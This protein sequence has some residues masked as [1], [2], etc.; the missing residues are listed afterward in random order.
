MRHKIKTLACIALVIASS[1]QLIG[2]GGGGDTVQTT[3]PG[4]NSSAGALDLSKGAPLGTIYFATDY[5]RT[6]TENGVRIEAVRAD[7]TGR[8][9][10]VNAATGVYSFSVNGLSPDGVWLSYGSFGTGTG[11][12]ANYISKAD[13]TAARRVATGEDAIRLRYTPDSQKILYSTGDF[14]TSDGSLI[15]DNAGGGSSRTVAA[16]ISTFDNPGNISWDISPD[17]GKIA[18]MSKSG[19]FVEKI[20]GSGKVDLGAGA[21]FKPGPYSFGGVFFSPDSS[22]IAIHLYHKTD[23]SKTGMYVLNADGSTNL[24]AANPIISGAIFKAQ[25]TRGSASAKVEAWTPSGSILYSIINTSTVSDVPDSYEWLAI[26]PDGSGS[27][28]IAK[29]AP[30][31][32]VN[33]SDFGR[34]VLSPDQTQMV[35]SS[36]GQL[37]RVLISGGAPLK[38]TNSAGSNIMPYFNTDGSKIVFTSSRDDRGQNL[39]S[40]GFIGGAA[41]TAYVIN[42]DGTNE[43]RLIDG[44]S[45]D[46]PETFR[47]AQLSGGKK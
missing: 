25:K 45:V 14:G 16:T 4:S 31:G 9:V 47:K 18:H 8:T 24:A 36:V 15:V 30:S 32:Y 5:A 13:G 10:V 3:V 38:L 20:D 12:I 11:A 44:Y 22:K 35:Y 40:P 7:G 28:S 39:A 21:N 26:N 23:D 46:Y 42:S 6:A 41:D 19:L 43:L 29:W 27:R 37:Y 1:I 17:G 2:C 33:V 34:A